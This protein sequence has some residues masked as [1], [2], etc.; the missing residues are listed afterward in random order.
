[1]QCICGGDPQTFAFYINLEGWR[2][3]NLGKKSGVCVVV[4]GGQGVGKGLYF[5][6]LMGHGVYGPTFVQSYSPEQL[7]GK[8]NG[9][10]FN[11][12]Y[13]VCDECV[14]KPQ[15]MQA[16][17]SMV[18]EEHM[19]LELKG[20][21]CTQARSYSNFTLLTNE[22]QPVPMDGQDR[23]LF[24]VECGNKVGDQA[25]Y[26]QL[27]NACLD[28]HI[29]HLW[30][31]YLFTMELGA[32]TPHTVPLTE[33]KRSMQLSSR[34]SE[35]AYLQSCAMGLSGLELKE[36]TERVVL[37][38]ELY[39]NYEGWMKL[40][41]GGGVPKSRALL[42]RVLQAIVPLGKRT[43]VWSPAA[44]LGVTARHIPSRNT[45]KAALQ[46]KGLWCDMQDV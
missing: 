14:I 38:S 1:M 5:S 12:L 11:K 8:F 7:V 31:R 41:W 29:Q 2:L 21:E 42:V 37:A 39:T 23:R 13:V 43:T 26:S 28:P 10:T 3:Q 9:M 6:Q 16:F 19:V 25:H 45:I 32:F 34:S 24:V 33:A 30:K 15:Q 36:D 18:T 4:K 17:K 22:E 46:T 44:Q 27:A 20:K 40:N 35:T